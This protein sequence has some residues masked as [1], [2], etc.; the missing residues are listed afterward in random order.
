TQNSAKLIALKNSFARIE[1]IASIEV[2][3]PQ[4]FER[5]AVEAIGAG[6]GN[7]VDNGSGKAPVFSIKRV[8]HQPEFLNGVEC[9]HDGSP[10]ISAF[11]HIATIHQKG[12]GRFPL[13][14][15]GNVTCVA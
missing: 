6:L 2:L 4:E 15:D 14:V 10:V 7:S 1:E 12:I 5:R 8:S 11:F 9:G 13:S 3:I